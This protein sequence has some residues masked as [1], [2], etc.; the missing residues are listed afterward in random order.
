MYQVF[1]KFEIEKESAPGG[2]IRTITKEAL[3]TFE[4]A[5]PKPEE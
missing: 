1:R 2:I 3:S 5:F 4:I